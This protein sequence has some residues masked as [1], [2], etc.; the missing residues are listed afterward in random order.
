MQDLQHTLAELE[1]DEREMAAQRLSGR[2]TGSQFKS[3]TPQHLHT[4][5]QTDNAQPSISQYPQQVRKC[6]CLWLM[7]VAK[8]E[9]EN[10]TLLDVTVEKKSNIFML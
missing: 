4:D 6:F 9:F 1:R 2:K 10:F 3:S 5:F 7:L 8:L